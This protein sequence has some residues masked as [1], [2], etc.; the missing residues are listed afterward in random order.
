MNHRRA[1]V[2]WGFGPFLNSF[3]W[4]TGV[5]A[6][7]TGLPAANLNANLRA[8]GPLGQAPRERHR[9]KSLTGGTPKGM[10][11]CQRA[12]QQARRRRWIRSFSTRSRTVLPVSRSIVLR[13]ATR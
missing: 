4:S 6:A 12:L 13:R 11:E 5:P 2:F 8:N 9:L 1:K 7:K 3:L 10:E